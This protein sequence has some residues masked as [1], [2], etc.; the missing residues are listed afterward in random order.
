MT[1]KPDFMADPNKAARAQGASEA[2]LSE[3]T[4]GNGA[5]APKEAP[6]NK[7]EA[8]A[9]AKLEAGEVTPTP[10]EAAAE[11]AEAEAAAATEAEEK[12]AKD[13]ADADAEAE[14][15]PLDNSV[16]GSTG[17][18]VGDSVL[19]LIQNAGIS[20]DEAKSLMFDAIRAGDI[21]QID[22]AALEAKVGKAKATL[23]MA[24]TR[25]FITRSADKAK[26][27]VA[28]VHK[29]VGGED[30]WSVI[31]AWAKTN[32]PEA[33]T[34]EYN[35]MIDAGGAKARFAASELAA[36]FNGDAKNTTLNADTTEIIGDGVAP[37]KTESLT[38]G[39]YVERMK[40]AHDTGA[41]P[42]AIQSIKD[43]R[44]RGRAKGI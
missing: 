4:D 13:K 20:T 30:N 41:T 29:T 7:A 39:Q 25:D 43:A 26:T 11:A 42:A 1:D 19:E 40:V 8:E 15:K 35:E 44:A 28:E 32:V 10:E 17:D 9:Q 2:D 14:N 18:E 22:V 23:I 33:E 31:T 37:P 38:R 21:N 16:W 36:R 27:I 34:A 6:K 3:G 24:G 12:A 5:P